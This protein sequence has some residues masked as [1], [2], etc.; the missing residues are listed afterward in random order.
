MQSEI[1][2][3]NRVSHD[4]EIQAVIQ[5]QTSPLLQKLDHAS[6]QISMLKR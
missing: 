6:S 2:K 1:E 3:I 4:E 5:L